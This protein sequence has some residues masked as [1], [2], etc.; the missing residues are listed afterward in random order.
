MAGAAKSGENRVEFDHDTIRS[1]RESW[2]AGDL[3]MDHRQ[4]EYTM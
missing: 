1:S 4:L 3:P 2:L